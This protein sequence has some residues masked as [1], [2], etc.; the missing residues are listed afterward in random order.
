MLDSFTYRSAAALCLLPAAFIFACATDTPR[1]SSDDDDGG[2]APVSTTITASDGG[3]V[4]SAEASLLVPPNA[5][6]TDS[7]VTLTLEAATQ[8]TLSQIYVF[9]PDGMVFLQ[10]ATL[11]ITTASLTP[12]A[13]Q[14][15]ALAKYSDNSWVPVAGATQLPSAIEASITTLSRFA[16]VSIASAPATPCDATCMA[17][18]GATCCTTCG[19]EAEV[20]C[21]PTCEWDCEVGCCFDGGDFLCE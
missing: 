2:T 1:S 3:T 11:S 6:D 19:C 5:V 7:E 15:L 20:P 14:Q 10:A 17:Q 13:D 18:P 9:S 12:P 16:I 4:A 8:D 21:A